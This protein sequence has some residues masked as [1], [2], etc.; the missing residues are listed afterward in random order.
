MAPMFP[1]DS[2]SL[3]LSYKLETNIP[4]QNIEKRVIY[5]T[6]NILF[7]IKKTEKRTA[8]RIT[9]VNLVGVET[10]GENEYY[11]FEGSTLK[12]GD[13]IQIRLTTKVSILERISVNIDVLDKIPI[14]I[15]IVLV[16]IFF[17]YQNRKK[18][19]TKTE[20]KETELIEALVDAEIA[21]LEEE[22]YTE[23]LGLV[24]EK[25]ES[26]S[27]EILDKNQAQEITKSSESR[28]I[29]L[30]N[31]SVQ[32]VAEKVLETIIEDLEE[33]YISE[34]TYQIIY[35]KYKK[36]SKPANEL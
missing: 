7:L 21:F 6:E 24:K 20:E 22:I 8:E 3:S 5:N 25:A 33:G 36:L 17:V 10:Y 2:Y 19:I 32:R 18:S 27:F 26:A 11:F 14:V 29:S 28:K 34:G 12:A 35:T 9:G 16:A 23:E 1:N 31:R 30:K 4:I 15:P 13:L